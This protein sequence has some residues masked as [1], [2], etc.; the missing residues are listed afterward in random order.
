MFHVIS[1]NEFSGSSYNN[2]SLYGLIAI[3]F[4]VVL[5]KWIF[6]L[7]S[8]KSGYNKK[9]TLIYTHLDFLD[10]EVER[11]LFLSLDFDLRP[12]ERDLDQSMLLMTFRN[13]GKAIFDRSFIENDIYH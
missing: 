5:G 2:R 4:H 11:D 10:L 9:N 13:S 8:L 12:L 1:V 7:Q 6:R 3:L